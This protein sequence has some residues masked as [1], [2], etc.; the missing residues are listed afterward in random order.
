MP[1]I[2]TFDPIHSYVAP[3]NVGSIT[4]SS[5]NQN[6]D[7]LVITGGFTRN[8][9]GSFGGRSADFVFNG[10]T[11]NYKAVNVGGVNGSA[12]FTSRTTN[13]TS[14]INATAGNINYQGGR[15]CFEVWIP[16]YKNVN[17]QKHALMKTYGNDTSANNGGAMQI[18]DHL[19]PTTSALT[20]L[21]IS[22]LVETFV[23]GDWVTIY[24]VKNA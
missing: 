21:T 18:V 1:V 19:I 23:T 14:T 10:I 4:F 22:E 11:S 7:H 3:S 2:A 24:G 17:F 6:Y 5:L 15:Q 9:D 8:I 20:S 13:G 16:N 12:I